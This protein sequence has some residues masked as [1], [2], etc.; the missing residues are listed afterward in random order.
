M[1]NNDEILQEAAIMLNQ[2]VEIIPSN[3]KVPE[4]NNILD[5]LKSELNKQSDNN[6]VYLMESMAE[7]TQKEDTHNK[8]GDNSTLLRK[9]HRF[10]SFENIISYFPNVFSLPEKESHS[11][12]LKRDECEIMANMNN[13][14]SN[15]KNE[16]LSEDDNFSGSDDSILNE[17]LINCSDKSEV[18]F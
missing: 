16:F 3:N 1:L 15:I 4:D 17:Y 5:A 6:K 2:A 11:N 10:N 7:K 8:R 13:L 14:F 12:R 9:R 18:K